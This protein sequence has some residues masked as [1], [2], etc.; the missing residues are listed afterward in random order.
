MYRLLIEVLNFKKPTEY[1][2][3]YTC[4]SFVWNHQ[5]NNEFVPFVEYHST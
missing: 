3:L 4:T 1:Y 2:V 5:C